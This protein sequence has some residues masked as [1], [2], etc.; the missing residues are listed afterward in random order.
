MPARKP[1]NWRWSQKP[2]V[3]WNT[4][5][6]LVQPF[7]GAQSRYPLWPVLS[8]SGSGYDMLNKWLTKFFDN[9]PEAKIETST[10][11]MKSV[12]SLTSLEENEIVLS[13]DVKG[14]YINVPVMDAIELACEALFTSGSPPPLSSNFQVTHGTGSHKCLFGSWVVPSGTSREMALQW[15][16]LELW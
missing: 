4:T 14:F 13:V 7:K 1:R 8:L 3:H 11:K 6:P 9:V 2:Q 5:S 12:L 10:V 15:E 16:H